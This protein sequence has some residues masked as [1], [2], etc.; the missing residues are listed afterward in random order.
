MPHLKVCGQDR[1]RSRGTTLTVFC[2]EVGRQFVRL[3]GQFIRLL[4]S[5]RVT[6]CETARYVRAQNKRVPKSNRI[7]VATAE[8]EFELSFA[9]GS[10]GCACRH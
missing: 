8:V 2:L 5:R 6:C 1:N 3:G 7:Q 9:T 4:L 10:S